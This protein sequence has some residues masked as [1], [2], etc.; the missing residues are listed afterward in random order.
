MAQRSARHATDGAVDDNLDTESARLLPNWRFQALRCCY[1]KAELSSVC[2]TRVR[3]FSPLP[4][5]AR[6]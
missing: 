2:C 3:P 4:K 6:Q 1:C 5:L